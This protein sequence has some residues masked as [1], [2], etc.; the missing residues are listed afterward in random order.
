MKYANPQGQSTSW[1]LAAL[2]APYPATAER[3]LLLFMR[4]L[5]SVIDPVRVYWQVED[6]P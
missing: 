2:L 3:G 6:S 1:R 5:L 4:R